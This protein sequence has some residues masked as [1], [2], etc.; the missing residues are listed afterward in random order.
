MVKIDLNSKNFCAAPWH[1]ILVDFGGDIIPDSQF[2]LSYGNIYEQTLDEIW[3]NPIPRATRKSFINGII[4]ENCKQCPKKEQTIGASRRTFFKGNLNYLLKDNNFEI[5]TKPDIYFLEINISNICN[6]KCRMCSSAASSAWVK[7]DEHILSLGRTYHRPKGFTKKRQYRKLK[8][9]IIERLFYNPH[10]FRNLCYLS[11]KGGEPFMEPDNYK[12]LDFMIDQNLAK[13]IILDLSTNGTIIDQKMFSYFK[14][15]KE[16]KL[17]VSIEATGKLYQ[18][19][20]GGNIFTIDQLEENLKIF[21]KL[22]NTRIIFA[23]TYSVYNLFEI[24]NLWNWFIKNRKENH[25]IYFHNIVV[26]PQYL[27]PCVLPYEY[28]KKASDELILANIPDTTNNPRQGSIGINGII[29]GILNKSYY[30][31]EQQKILL[32][33]CKQFTNDID[34]LRNTNI[35]EVL[36]ELRC[37]YD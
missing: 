25:E 37:L 26:T 19:I 5:D 29:K 36:P 3:Q 1:S 27:H 16:V 2:W 4:P 11:L 22:E 9:N 12:I 8:G 35:K 28:R 13:N 32:E 20:R 31:P 34:K 6:L 18:Y 10:N 30:T 24:P 17:H 23:T 33:Q 14:F 15:F 7:E 21:N